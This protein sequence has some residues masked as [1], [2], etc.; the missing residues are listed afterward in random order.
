MTTNL[1]LVDSHLDLAFDA[2]QLKRDLTASVASVRAHDPEPVI[3]SFG[4]CTVTFPELRK[5][6]V[7]LV[8]GTVMTRIDPNDAWTAT[9]MYARSPTSSVPTLRVL[10]RMLKIDFAGSADT[11]STEP[12]PRTEN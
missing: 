7:G 9:G 12:I 2:I 10:D 11:C 5:G 1:L 4:T 8:F 6:G 3:R